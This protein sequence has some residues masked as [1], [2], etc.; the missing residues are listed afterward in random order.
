MTPVGRLE[1]GIQRDQQVSP[2]RLN[3]VFNNQVIII[4]I[5]FAQNQKHSL[6]YVSACVFYTKKK[7]LKTRT[8]AFN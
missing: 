4:I 1:A 5:I 3:S 8:M 7:V 6:F 2:P